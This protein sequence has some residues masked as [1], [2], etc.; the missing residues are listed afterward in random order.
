MQDAQAAH[1]TTR[2]VLEID[3]VSYSD[4]ARVLEENLNV[5]AV[6]AFEDQIQAFVDH[7]LNALGLQRDAI[8]LGTAGDNAILIFDDAAT[9]HQ[10]A[11]VVQQET[12]EHNRSKSVE[13][14]KRWFRM[15]AATGTVLVLASERRIVGSTIARAIRLE[16]AA[17]RG[18]LVVD[19]PTFDAL[20]EDLKRYYGL[21]EVVEG[22]RD[23]LFTVRRCTLADVPD[24]SSALGIQGERPR[25]QQPQSVQL[26][27]PLQAFGSGED[28]RGKLG[29]IPPVASRST[30]RA[31]YR[32]L[33]LGV[34]TLVLAVGLVFGIRLARDRGQPENR[35]R[36]SIAVL[37]FRNLSGDPSQDYVGDG[38]TEDL[39]TDL[40]RIDGAFVIAGNTMQFYRGKEV[41]I[42]QVGRELGVRYLLEGSIQRA[43]RLVRVTAQLIDTETGAHVWA[44]RFDRGA[45]DLLAL[46]ADV[47]RPIARALHRQLKEAE[48][49]RT[50]HARPDTLEAIAY[51]RKAW[52]ELWTKPQTKATNEQALAYLEQ[53]RALDPNVP[54]MWANLAYAQGRAAASRWSPSPP[55]SLR[56]AREAGERAVALNPRSAA[57]HYALG[58]ALRYQAD[59]DRALAEF[60]TAVALNPNHAAA[61]MQIGVC[62]MMRGRPREA[63]LSFD[64]AFRLSP[65]ESQ[66]AVWHTYVGQAYVM[67]GEDLKAL[68]EGKQAAE[69][70]PKLPGAFG[71]QSTALALLGREAEAR[72]AVAM[73]QQVAPGL[74]VT[75]VKGLFRSDNLEYN[76]LMERYYD[77]L[78]KAGLP[79]G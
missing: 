18:Q 26:H 8:V 68:G 67:L 65:R 2:T 42:R 4:I 21:E 9:M 13:L 3:L 25:P 56:L 61:H 66:R 57:A 53:A 5:E 63:L 39:T 15:G 1:H 27:S 71:L 73:L 47:T 19:L 79:E 48:S 74:T 77:G 45:E 55:E 76:R 54:E 52:T 35:S 32:P 24:D 49:P 46:H 22:K 20:P 34:F 28:H 70:N 69:A 10:F 36:L 59:I 50:M 38:L 37:P 12:L 31:R 58:F 41:D 51:T 29:P 17:H 14:A 44:K 23:E 40:S 6:K 78:R 60:E 75:G 64:R 43:E 72:A 7:G 16:A 33:L 30:V 11:Q 62:W